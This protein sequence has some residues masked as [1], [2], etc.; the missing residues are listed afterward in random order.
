M[1]ELAMDF[2]VQSP[3]QPADPA[4]HES[5]LMKKPSQNVPDPARR[6]G[7]KKILRK[8]ERTPRVAHSSPLLA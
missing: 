4:T 7:R 5:S 3:T 6:R 1:K 2:E 8:L